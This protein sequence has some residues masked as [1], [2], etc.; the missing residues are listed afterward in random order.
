MFKSRKRRYK[1]IGINIYGGGFTLGALN[2]F[3]VLGQWEEFKL[4]CVGLS[5]KA[6]LKRLNGK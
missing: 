5:G 2:H 3:E 1:A 6:A 4:G